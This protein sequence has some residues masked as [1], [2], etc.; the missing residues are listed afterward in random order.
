MRMFS[1]YINKFYSS[2]SSVAFDTLMWIVWGSCVAI[3]AATLIA[4][5]LSPKIKSASKRPYLCLVNAYA[6]LT[7]AAFLTANGLAQSILAAVLF[8]CAG[9]VS[10][11]LLCFITPKLVE[12]KPSAQLALS[13]ISVQ[14]QKVATTRMETTP[15]K[16]SVRLEHAISVTD[17]LLQKNL[18]KGDRQELEKLKN[19]LAVLQ[20]RG[21]LSPAEADIL[22]D[23][24]N[25]LLK[26][27][28]K[29]NM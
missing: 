28:A 8:W 4:C 18:G 20:M 14:P 1:K 13:S 24:F 27:M 11:G 16:S 9:Y 6:A 10:Y 22:N 3:F 29:Y 23:N 12:E 7:L 25:A 17:K 15:A 2:L 5:F 21:T 19:T 26:L